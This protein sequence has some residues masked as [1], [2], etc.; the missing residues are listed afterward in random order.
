MYMRLTGRIIRKGQPWRYIVR[1]RVC[2]IRPPS[3][4]REDYFGHEAS[5]RS[6][7]TNT[8]ARRSKIISTSVITRVL[9]ARAWVPMVASTAE[10]LA[11]VSLGV[12][13]SLL[14]SSLQ[15]ITSSV[16]GPWLVR[17]LNGTWTWI[18]SW[19]A[20]SE[21]EG[22]MGGGSAYACAV[23]QRALLQRVWHWRSKGRFAFTIY[24][25]SRSN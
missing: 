20:E 2:Y 17:A 9:K 24:A 6:V 25:L 4:H 11:M 21:T 22:V 19:R 15:R 5:F 10:L 18:Y 7:R 8:W 14:R 13:S 16:A 1:R 3:L 12:S 23:L